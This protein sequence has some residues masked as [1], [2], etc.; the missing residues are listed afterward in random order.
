M[1]QISPRAQQLSLRLR[2]VAPQSGRRRLEAELTCGVYQ[3]VWAAPLF[4][5]LG[6]VGGAG[7]L[8]LVTTSLPRL[9]L[10]GLSTVIAFGGPGTLASVSGNS[11]AGLFQAPPPRPG[12]PRRR[13]RRQPCRGRTPDTSKGDSPRH[14]PA[15]LARDPEDILKEVLRV[16]LEVSLGRAGG[17]EERGTRGESPKGKG[18][19]HGVK[20]VCSRPPDSQ[21]PCGPPG[22][23]WRRHLFLGRGAKAEET[24]L[25]GVPLPLSHFQFSISP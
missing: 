19:V 23:S 13:R 24:R 1:R 17:L 2:L 3:P 20:R 8:T 21:G 10:A 5:G 22:G 15:L 6:T 14:S 11:S 7:G 18:P 25:P 4:G 9:R 12:P 16:G